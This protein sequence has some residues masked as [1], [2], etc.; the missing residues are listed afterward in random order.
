M[1]KLSLPYTY[2]PLIK[3]SLIAKLC[4]MKNI[5]LFPYNPRVQ[6]PIPTTSC[7][8]SWKD[9]GIH[10]LK[11]VGQLISLLNYLPTTSHHEQPH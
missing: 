5:L 2:Q 6:M 9:E 10:L 11:A 7:S 4:S 8:K 3:A 1:S